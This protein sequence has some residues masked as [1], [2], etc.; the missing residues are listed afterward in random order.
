MTV[1]QDEKAIAEFIRTKGVTR[2]PTACAAPTH[3]SVNATDRFALRCRAEQL[4]ALRL[5]RAQMAWS[6]V[7]GGVSAAPSLYR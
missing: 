4:E 1:P 3:G 6:H 2:C 5:E 7:F